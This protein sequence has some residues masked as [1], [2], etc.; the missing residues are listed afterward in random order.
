MKL[1][2]LREACRVSSI[3]GASVNHSVDFWAVISCR[4]LFRLWRLLSVTFVMASLIVIRTE[5][6][7]KKIRPTFREGCGL[8]KV[9]WGHRVY[10]FSQKKIATLL[11]W[12]SLCKEWVSDLTLV[13]VQWRNWRGQGCKQP[14]GKLNVKAGPHWAYISVLV[15][16]WFSVGCFLA[17]FRSI[18]W[19][20]LV[21]HP[22]PDS[23]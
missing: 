12:V 14:P 19:W 4:A 17:F 8:P 15:F 9:L 23:P 2:L 22:H 5:Q 11:E 7:R 1:S 21:S 18:F 6:V 3:K 16:F 13:Y 10:W 20:F